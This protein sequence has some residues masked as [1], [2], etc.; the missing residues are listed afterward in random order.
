M[1]ASLMTQV[2]TH[3]PNCKG[4]LEFFSIGL[5]EMKKIF[6]LHISGPCDRRASHVKCC[7][8]RYIN[9]GNDV[10]SASEMKIV[11]IFNS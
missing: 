10:T 4:L 6:M 11:I 8:K 5:C 3:F 1:Y 7:I 9:E 2:F